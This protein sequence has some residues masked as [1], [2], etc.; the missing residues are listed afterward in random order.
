M[1]YNKEDGR[2]ELLI[3]PNG[4][5]ALSFEAT[6]KLFDTE[7]RTDAEKA[8]PQT[9]GFTVKG[10]TLVI[11]EK[12]SATF[13]GTGTHTIL[14]SIDDDGQYVYKVMAGDQTQQEEPSTP[15]PTELK[16]YDKEKQEVLSTLTK[17]GDGIYSGSLEAKWGWF[18][19]LVYDAE[20]SIWY[21]SDPADATML[22][23]EEGF[24]NLWIPADIT[25]IF[26]IT[27]DLNTMKWTFER[28]GD[29]P[30]VYPSE[31]RIYGD[32]DWGNGEPMATLSQTEEGKY[33][34]TLTTTKAWHSFQVVDATQ[35]TWVWYGAGEDSNALKAG[36]GNLWTGEDIGDY[37]IEVNLSTMTWS[38]TF[39]SE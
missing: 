9:Y 28:T 25:G 3:E 21:G 10:D 4:E 18:N 39:K 29:L 7:S 27:V 22:S 30:P 35:T 34:G 14:V 16:V 31:L 19:F 17:T 2:W 5:T 12:G 1:K 6:A 15:K 13:T 38:A 23:S 33:S 8:K 32:P 11:G 37:T 24:Y 36:G 20:N 26:T